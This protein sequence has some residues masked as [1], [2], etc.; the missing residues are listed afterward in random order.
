MT[1][2]FKQFAIKQDRT[3]M[4]V[5]TDGVLLG[6]WGSIEHQPESILDIGAGTGVIALMLAQRSLATTIDAVEIE[7]NAYLQC[8]DNFENSPWSDRLFCYHASIQELAQDPE[9]DRYD[10]VVANPPFFPPPSSEEIDKNRKTAR[11][12]D[13]LPFEELIYGASQ[14]LSQQGHLAL[15]VPF[16]AEEKVCQMAKQVGLFPWKI[17]RVQGTPDAPI[18]RSLIQYSYQSRPL[19]ID[20]LVIEVSRHQYTDEYIQLVRDFYL[21]L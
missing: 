7:E 20:S 13:Q 11:Y 17:S 1:F 18:K 5:G 6:A 14:L 15:V 10:L 3:A 21:K 19:K 12:Y 4:K 9:R 8:V 16:N 2:L